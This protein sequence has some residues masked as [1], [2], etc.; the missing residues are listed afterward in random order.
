MLVTASAAEFESHRPQLFGLAYRL[1]GSA[2]DAEDV[3]Q[4]AFLRWTRADPALIDSPP[5]WLGKIVT[6]LCLNALAS[7]RVQRE[8]YVGPWLPEP[9]LTAEGQLGPLETAERRESVSLALLVLL[10]HLTPPERGVFV[11]REAFG[12]RYREIAPVLGFSEANCR[13]IYRR[14]TQRLGSR[15]PR[16]TASADQQ[17]TITRQFLAAASGADLPGLERLLSA[18]VVAWADGGGQVV[19]AR[20]AVRGRVQVARYLAGVVRWA[21]RNVEDVRTAEILLLEVNGEPALVARIGE[22]VLG[23]MVLEIAGGCVSALR[24]SAN[25]QKLTFLAR[26]LSHP[27]RLPGSIAEGGRRPHGLVG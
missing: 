27:E 8:R 11:L 13:Q 2:A 24:I 7:A 3:V 5:A 6:N 9:V 1:L 10:E 14:A 16:F 4:D 12:Y 23:A 19:A 15:E 18:D 26:Q 22:T 25:P 21:V 17:R 20:R